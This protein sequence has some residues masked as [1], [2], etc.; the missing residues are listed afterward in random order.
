[1]VAHTRE[2]PI[3]ALEKAGVYATFA[4]LP[5]KIA[6]RLLTAPITAHT[7]NKTWRRVVSHWA[8]H[9]LTHLNIRQWVFGNS[10]DVYVD[11]TQKIG[12]QQRIDE[13]DCPG[14]ALY[15]GKET[16]EGGDIL[17]GGRLMWVGER[18]L[19]RVNIFLHGGAFLV[20]A[21]AEG[22]P[23]WTWMKKELKGRGVDTGLCALSYTLHPE[24]PY[25]LPL[26]QLIAALKHLI[27][28][29]VPPEGIT[30]VGESAGSN[31]I[32]MLFSHMLHPIGSSTNPVTGQ[33]YVVPEFKLPAGHKLGGVYL[34]SPWIS[35]GGTDPGNS[36]KENSE[37]DIT[38]AATLL[39]WGQ[40]ILDAV[41]KEQQGTEGLV[42]KMLI[43]VGQFEPLRNSIVALYNKHFRGSEWDVKGQESRVTYIYQPF[44]NH[45]D[46]YYDFFWG[47]EPKELGR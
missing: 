46:P 12:E 19:K 22:Y 47:P 4:S 26:I 15:S 21:P 44:G 33:T 17:M 28:L 3:S 30:L 6:Y 41:P 31:L 9:Y 16:K 36:F 43:S 18:N 7:K 34:L 38:S 42:E 39:K 8:V 23:F 37:S 24:G 13:L 29:G 27:A 40:P 45:N 35:V 11:W 32:L 2:V 20:H 10:Y 1:M 5:S 14:G 25:P